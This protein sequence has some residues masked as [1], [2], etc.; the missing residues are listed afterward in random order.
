MNE[1]SSHAAAGARHTR[2]AAGLSE[3]ERWLADQVR[4]GLAGAGER[5]WAELAR[6]LVDAQAPGV[7]GAV[8]RLGGIR[9]AAGWPE[10]L[11]EEYA[12][13]HLLAVG[14]RRSGELPGDLARTVRTRVGFP[15]PREEVLAG[16]G[17]R[18]LWHVVGRR[19]ETRDRLVARRVWLKGRA[20]GRAALVLTFAPV[21]HALDD[22]LAAGDVVDACLAFYPGAAPLRA[23]VSARHDGL[24]PPSPP[25]GTTE[26]EALEQVAAA[27]AGD[28][29]TE[30][31]PLVLAG[32]V[33]SAGRL[34]GLRLHPRLETPWRL[35]AVSGGR[36]LTVA[37]EW[38][39]RGLVPLTA[40]DE[41]GQAVIL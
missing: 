16:P 11:L 2:V 30:S 13:L 38:T 22:S 3:L 21:G 40:W 27:L 33:P 5:E 15:I 25:P 41:Q 8:G 7:A 36:P 18:D 12:L 17:V 29:W 24:R 19:D 39:P 34:G 9:A 35:I 31:W 23:L 6:R 32:V 26:R 4:H 28:P 20:T 1:R 37:A 14:Y 10:R